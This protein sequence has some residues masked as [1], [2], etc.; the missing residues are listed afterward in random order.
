MLSI[1]LTGGIGSGKSLAGEFFQELGA[2]VIDSD[3]LAREVIERGTEGFD[4]VLS[5][6]GDE[7]LNGGEIDRS[8]L[9]EIV[10]KDESARRDLEEII[11]PKVRE[12]ALKI[13]ARVPSDGVVINQIPLLFETKGAGRFDFVITVSA[14]LEV[15][16]ARL[17][18]RG[19][20]SYEI[21]RRISAQA[22]DSQRESIANFIIRNNGSVEELERAVAELWER[23]ILPRVKK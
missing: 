7:I 10:F 14:D 6:F 5:R 8:K 16:K 2:V 13:A 23:E 15:R 9:A 11:H 1:A 12:A 20:K 4:E 19:L 3:Q 21:E 22:T 17:N 18:E